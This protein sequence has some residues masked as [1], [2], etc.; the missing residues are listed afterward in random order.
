M[1][2][3]HTPVLP[4]LERIATTAPVSGGRLAAVESSA[5]PGFMAPLHAHAADEA[6]HVLEGSMTVYAGEEVVRLAA[7]ETFVVRQGVAHTYRTGPDGARSVFTTFAR[8]A[9]R[10]E[11]FLRAAGPLPAGAPAWAGDDDAAAV[12]AVA[13]AAGVAVLGPPGLLPVEVDPAARAA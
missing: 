6:V 9:G 2:Q 13:A 11:D 5:S 10:Y 1:S 7:G 12:T 4:L 8:S 3:T